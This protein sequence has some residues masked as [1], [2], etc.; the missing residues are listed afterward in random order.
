[1]VA[2][3]GLLLREVKPEKLSS[4]KD[5]HPFVCYIHPIL[6][7]I[8]ILSFLELKCL[9]SCNL[10]AKAGATWGVICFF[11][12]LVFVLNLPKFKGAC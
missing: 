5:N 8:V 6:K 12:L 3:T 1:M 9:L 7:I 10:T 2:M 11:V 4:L